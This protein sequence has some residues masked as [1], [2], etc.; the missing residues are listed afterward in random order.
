MHSFLTGA[1]KSEIKVSTDLVSN[2][3][4]LPS[5]VTSSDGRGE[6]SISSGSL[7]KEH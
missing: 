3:S 1:G 5:P 2:E 4:R 6:D 7:L